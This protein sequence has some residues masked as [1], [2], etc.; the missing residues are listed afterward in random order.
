MLDAHPSSA[1]NMLY[2][3]ELFLSLLTSILLFILATPVRNVTLSP[4]TLFDKSCYHTLHFYMVWSPPV[5][6]HIP[7]WQIYVRQVHI[8]QMCI[9]CWWWLAPG[10]G[11]VFFLGSSSV[12]WPTG[13]CRRMYLGVWQ[14]PK[15]LLPTF[16]RI[17]TAGWILLH[18]PLWRSCSTASRFQPGDTRYGCLDWYM[19]VKQSTAVE[20]DLP[21]FQSSL[22][23]YH[24]I[25]LVSPDQT[26]PALAQECRHHLALCGAVIVPCPTV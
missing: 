20:E 6:W 13:R 2:D 5:T 15:Y 25:G 12:C 4:D 3:L 7:A 10:K 8:M 23:L 16:S 18:V 24:L 21:C 14:L 1:T 26:H 22:P 19:F 17:K 11:V 9:A